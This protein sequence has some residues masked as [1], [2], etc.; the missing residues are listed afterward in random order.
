M[1]RIESDIELAV[2]IL[3]M[4]GTRGS[5]PYWCYLVV[6]QKMAFKFSANTQVFSLGGH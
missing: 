6:I 5:L 4:F 2:Q 1:A 3:I